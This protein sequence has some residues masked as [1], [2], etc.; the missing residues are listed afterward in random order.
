MEKVKG[1]VAGELDE[2]LSL[3]DESG[4]LPEGIDPDL[5]NLVLRAADFKVLRHLGDG[6]LNL[7]AW[8]A[9]EGASLDWA[10]DIAALLRSEH[11]IHPIVREQMADVLEGRSFAGTTLT[12]KGG[13]A[14]RD[15]VAGI[16]ARRDRARIGRWIEARIASGQKR[17]DAILF[18]SNEFAASV[19]K[20]GLA[21]DYTRKLEKHL[22]ESGLQGRQKRTAEDAFHVADA[23]GDRD[24]RKA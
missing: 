18:A 1:S 22:A 13:K 23:K 11:P 12:L 5:R 24:L 10:G 7:K 3:F 16:E 17:K 21:L 4:E 14:S 20:C 9:L 8:S 2:L 6:L 19:E 15:F